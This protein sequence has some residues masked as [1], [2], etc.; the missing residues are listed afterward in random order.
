MLKLDNQ[1]GR[2]GVS[3]FCGLKNGYNTSAAWDKQGPYSKL[4]TYGARS[5]AIWD[6]SNGERYRA[7]TWSHVVMSVS[8]P[9]LS[10][11]LNAHLAPTARYMAQELARDAKHAIPQVGMFDC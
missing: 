1:T 10:R 9:S 6:A 7:C 4:C 3:P 8:P 2:L 11:A 5:F